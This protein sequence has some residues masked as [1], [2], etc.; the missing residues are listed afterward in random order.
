V[1]VSAHHEIHIVQATRQNPC[2]HCGVSIEPGEMVVWYR[3]LKD[4]VAHTRCAL[5]AI[6]GKR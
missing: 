1:K 2:T 4:F 3:P 6:R 5:E